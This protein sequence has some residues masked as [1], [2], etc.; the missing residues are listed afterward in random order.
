[1][2]TS[3][4]RW[5]PLAL[6]VSVAGCAST[7]P[8]ADRPMPDGPRVADYDV[9]DL[10]YPAL[11]DV[12][13]PD[14]ERVEFAN[15]LTVF[16]VED[17]ALP[18][19]EA[20][21]L[22]ATGSVFDPADEAG[23]AAVTAS[24]MRTGGAG[25]RTPDEV[26]L[27]LENVGAT[28]EVF[29]G[30]DQTT[31]IASGLS[32]VFVSDILPIFA[33]VLMAPAFDEEQVGLVKTQLR[34]AIASRNDDAQSIAQREMQQLLLG[35]DSPYA[36]DVEYA[37]LDAIDLDDVRAFHGR[38]VHPNATVMAVSGDFDADEMAAT[39]RSTFAGWARGADAPAPPAQ[40]FQSGPGLYFIP[41][42][43]VNQSTIL[44][45]H[46]GELR[47]DSPD[48]PAVLV[49]NEVLGGGFASRLFQTVRTDL[50]L[51]YAVFGRYAADYDRP[52]IFFSGTFTKSESTVQAAQAVREVI[53]SMRTTAPTDQELSLAKASYLN[54]FVFNFDT[55]SEVLNRVLTY[56]R[57]GYPTDYLQTLKDRV[58]AVTAADVQRVAQRYLKPD[59]AKVLVL[60]RAADFDQP[61]TALGTPVTIDISIPSGAD[62]GPAG[63]PVAGRAALRRAAEALGGADRF[64]ALTAYQSTSSTDV[65]QGQMAGATIAGTTLVELPGRV[66]STQQT[67][68][69]EITVVLNDGRGLL[70]LPGGQSQP[71]PPPVA[72]SIRDQLFL[73][74]PYLMA[75]LDDLEAEALAPEDGLDRVRVRA[76]GLSAPI[77]LVLGAD[78]RPVRATTTQVGAEGPTE[79][80][81]AFS[82]YRSVGGLMLPFRT[83]QSQGGEVA[84]TTTVE[85]YDF[86]P[87][88][89][90][91]AFDL[92]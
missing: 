4:L 13:L 11:R 82:D 67:P 58:E 40:T 30:D 86:S 27:A 16:L 38:Y 83:V 24:A 41:K 23:L 43:D 66:R 91:D 18:L 62:D 68:F 47:L 8:V 5:A 45:G 70:V 69:G 76:P 51:A 74:L 88:V 54:S 75:R 1:M 80:T 63:D 85:A 65:A 61:L 55:K 79:A 21:A 39:L 60:G 44:I 33:D 64:A 78:G 2:T 19:I 3:F 46:P 50:G 7:G 29:A 42:D 72:A 77:T 25:G 87:T 31:A 81:V 53:E 52:G 6:A 32:D 17:R 12:A 35:E 22:V 20:R 59:E 49:M 28:V 26:N 71:A 89:A 84:Q 92:E 37:T 34:T 90:A 48:Y 73:D 10:E 36:R 57:Y 15:G 9:R 56:E 14:I